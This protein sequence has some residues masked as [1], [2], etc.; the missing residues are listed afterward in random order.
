MRADKTTT[1]ARKFNIRLPA[2]MNGMHAESARA[3]LICLEHLLA[4]GCLHRAQDHCVR[5]CL[6]RSP[7][8]G[9]REG[10][11]MV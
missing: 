10:G 8:M 2:N 1:G 7:S 11:K 3:T 4:S 6:A 5:H 9:G